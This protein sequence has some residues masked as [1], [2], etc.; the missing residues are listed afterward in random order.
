[1]S[2]RKEQKEQLRREREQREREAKATTRRKQLVGYGIGGVLGLAAVV[3]IVL[4]ISSSGGG[5]SGP[6][7]SKPEAGSLPGG[8]SAP[9]AQQPDLAAAVKAAGCTQRKFPATSRQHLAPGDPA[10]KYSSDPPTSGSHDAEPA[11]DGAYAKAP[12]K[13]NVLHAKE[14]GRIVY[15]YQPSLPK[16]DIANLKALFDEDQYQIMLVPDKTMKAQVAATAW[17]KDPA[18]NG[19]GNLLEC[20]RYSDK[21]FDA[22]RDFKEQHRGRGPEPVP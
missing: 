12:A 3:V 6:G 4:L 10:P 8:G 18:P 2:S 21:V 9:E 15:W 17:D 13:G 1:M 22:L 5:G 11:E 14:H 7:G 20:P 16:Q 19:T